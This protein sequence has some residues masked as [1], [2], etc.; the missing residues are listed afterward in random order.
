PAAPAPAP[1]APAAPRAAISPSYSALIQQALAR[2][3][4]YPSGARSRRS[5][6]VAMV[7]FT[8]RRDG[9][10]V[11]A[12]LAR[13]SG[14]GE[15]DAEAESMPSRASSLPPLPADWPDATMELVV[16]IRFVLR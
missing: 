14:D 16:P 15:L 3:Q 2:V 10:V 13:S 4:R 6:G 11:T 7:R 8:M 5:E 9:S 12:R 1:A